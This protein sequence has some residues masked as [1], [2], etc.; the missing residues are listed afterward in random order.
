MS[1]LH[2]LHVLS[3]S[4][5]PVAQQKQH[6]WKTGDVVFAKPASASPPGRFIVLDANKD[7][8]VMALKMKAKSE[9]AEE[10]GEYMHL[11]SSGLNL[12]EPGL[13]FGNPAN[14]LC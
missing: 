4:P 11:G 13:D 14:S 10:R 5:I 9:E 6:G 8:R 3:K 7:G 1:E 12:S 2:L